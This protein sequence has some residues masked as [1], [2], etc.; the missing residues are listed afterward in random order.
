M[1][2]DNFFH[3]AVLCEQH[4]HWFFFFF[5]I[6]TDTEQ[7]RKWFGES[8]TPAKSRHF[9]NLTPLSPFCIKHCS[10]LFLASLISAT[11]H[12]YCTF[13]L[14]VGVNNEQLRPIKRHFLHVWWA[15]ASVSC[16]W[17]H[18]LRQCNRF[19]MAMVHIDQRPEFFCL[20]CLHA[21]CHALSRLKRYLLVTFPQSESDAERGSVLPF[22]CWMPD[23][24]K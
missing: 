10:I 19:H 20:L 17:A 23:E 15:Q 14:G 12:T 11:K 3:A 22:R 13:N 21:S 18:S 4:Q 24:P 1:P 5:L 7:G 6:Q 2:F 16:V 8:I 9:P